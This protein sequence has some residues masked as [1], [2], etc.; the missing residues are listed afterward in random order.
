MSK[1]DLTLR[2]PTLISSFRDNLKPESIDKIEEYT[3]LNALFSPLVL[4]DNNGRIES[5]LATRFSWMNNATIA[6][7]FDRPQKTADG[8]TVGAED[9]ARSLKRMILLDHNMHGSL[10][11]KIIVP[12]DFHTIND[13]LPAIKVENDVLYIQLKARD[14]A[15]FHILASA[16]YAI[17]P[18]GSIDER[19]LRIIDF[20]NTTGPYYLES[21]D[22]TAAILSMNRDHFRLSDQNAAKI[23]YRKFSNSSVIAEAFK[24]HE[25]DHIPTASSLSSRDFANLSSLEGVSI[26]QTRDIG[27]YFAA[28]T[29]KARKRFNPTE[30]ALI[31]KVVQERIQTAIESLSNSAKKTNEFFHED[32]IGYISQEMLQKAQR[33]LIDRANNDGFDLKTIDISMEGS[34]IFCK[35]SSSVLQNVF[36]SLKTKSISKNIGAIQNSDADLIFSGMDVGFKED[37]TGIGF[38]IELGIF[39]L[40][41]VEGRKWLQEVAQMEASGDRAKKIEELHLR[42]LAVDPTLIPLYRLPTF[43][44]TQ[45]GWKMDLPT[46]WVTERLWQIHK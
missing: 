37:F 30:R 40:S 5:N 7:Y 11:D 1:T 6:F 2:V 15:I 16:D 21:E 46:L 26:H 34:E 18:A 31:A 39:P 33:N 35:I 14:A 17:I 43:A 10:A 25:L 20:R 28:F 24:N 8:H 41:R 32:G 22:E 3:I 45:N 36:R 19:T 13:S 29:D 9:A 4:F 42:A 12:E 38:A 27:L 44:A 23:I